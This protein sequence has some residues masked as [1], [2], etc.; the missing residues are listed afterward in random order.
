MDF[1]MLIFTNIIYRKYIVCHR[2]QLS[3]L[4]LNMFTRTCLSL[5]T[6]KTLFIAFTCNKFEYGRE[7]CVYEIK[8]RYKL[9]KFRTRIGTHWSMT[10]DGGFINPLE[11]NFKI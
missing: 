10:V 2:N 9:I 8:L 5:I 3:K 7:S 6:L 1:N 11:T 4:K